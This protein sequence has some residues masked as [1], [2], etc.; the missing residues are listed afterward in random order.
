MS[1]KCAIFRSETS[2]TWLFKTNYNRAKEGAAIGL[3][4][5]FAPRKFVILHDLQRR[6]SSIAFIPAYTSPSKNREDARNIREARMANADGFHTEAQWLARIEYFG[7]QCR[8]CAVPLT[9]ST[10]TKD[11][12]VAIANHGT[13]WASNLVPACKSCNS[14]KRD[15]RIRLV[16]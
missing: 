9:L 13:Q 6:S 4:R 8:Y 5:E 3:F 11:H 12:Q 14:W 10:V 7:W 1:L 16:S 2:P 15:R